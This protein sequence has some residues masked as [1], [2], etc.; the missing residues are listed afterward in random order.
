MFLE[1]KNFVRKANLFIMKKL[2]GS[3]RKFIRKEKARLRR[4]LLDYKECERLIGELYLKLNKQ[5]IRTPEAEAAKVKEAKLKE[6]KPKIKPLMKVDSKKA[7][8]AK[9]QKPKSIPPLKSLK[10]IQ[11]GKAA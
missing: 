10:K 9:E 7:V 3:I 6:A 8:V 2:P 1:E 5:F 11:A 4:S